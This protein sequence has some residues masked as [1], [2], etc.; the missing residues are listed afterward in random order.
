MALNVEFVPGI[1]TLGIKSFA[2]NHVK[3][4]ITN[5]FAGGFTIRPLGIKAPNNGT[6]DTHEEGKANKN[7]DAP[8]K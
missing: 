8:C 4:T 1:E 7:P 5:D 3:V 2:I 6:P